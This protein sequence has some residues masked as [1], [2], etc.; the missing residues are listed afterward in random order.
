MKRTR[1]GRRGGSA[2]LPTMLAEMAFASCET[3]ARRTVMM[4]AGT[5]SAA[6]YRRMVAEKAE[7]IYRSGVALAAPGKGDKMV[8][9][10]TPWHRG[11]TANAKRLRKR[12]R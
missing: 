7:A 3:I 12:N 6:E 8:A 10:L 11:V 2:K 9:V 1:R 5:C 4:A